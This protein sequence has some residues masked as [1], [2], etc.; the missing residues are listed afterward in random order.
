MKLKLSTSI[1]LI[2][3]SLQFLK[4]QEQ[5]IPIETRDIGLYLTVNPK[6]D[7]FMQYLGQKLS[8]PADILYDYNNNTPNSKNVEG[9]AYPAFGN[10]NTN[11]V[12]LKATHADGNLTT[13]LKYENHR[14]IRVSDNIT[15]TEVNLKD[16]A[17][18]FR[19]SLYYKA[20]SKENVFEVH[21]RIRHQESKAVKLQG[22]ASG[23]L[24]L[25]ADSYWL[26]HFYGAWAAEM[27]MVEECL[28][29]GIK[30]VDSKKGIRTTQSESPSFILSLDQPANEDNGNVIIG[31]LGWSGN[32]K[33]NFQVDNLNNLYAFGGMSDF[34]SDYFLE[35]DT[36]MTL[37]PLIFTYSTSGTGNA[38]R[39]L[40]RWAREYQLRDGNKVR[41]VMLNS[42]EGAYFNFDEKTIKDMI[43]DAALMGVELFVLDDGWFGN[44]YPRN[45]D[46]AGLGDWEVNR[47]KLP[48]GLEALIGY[49]RSKNIRFGIWVEPEMANPKSELAEKHPEWVVSGKNREPIL[50]RSQLVLDLT[51][52][53]VQDF[54][55]RCVADLLSQH[56]DIAYIKWDANRH[57]ENLSSTFLPDDRQSHFWI[58][59]IKGLYKVYEKL[60]AQF[61]DVIF[62]ACSSGGGRADYGALKYHHEFWASDNTDAL[63][64][65]YINWGFNQI[66]PAISLGSHVSVSPNHQTQHESP[67]KFRFDVAMSQRLGLE[68]QP[69]LLSQDEL[70]WTQKAVGT[71]KGIREVVQSGNQY[72]L[73]SPYEQKRASMMYVSDD[74]SKAILF[75]YILGYHYREDYPVIKLKGLDPVKQYR[76]TELLPLQKKNK[77]G[78]SVDKNAFA[79][80]G[81]VFSGDFLMK[82]GIRIL[83][84]YTYESAVFE[85]TEVK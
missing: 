10:G 82:Y 80:N 71:Y 32:Y 66:F 39:N 1:C 74:Q 67:I 38:S 57:I 68:L 73:I 43:D 34:M 33:L 83:I 54:V 4:A 3:L 21:A 76:I 70:V 40:H 14:T 30:T 78:E 44:K 75:A 2:I 11:E 28:T 17:Y 77:K 51:H 13:V 41:P 5:V 56:P 8:K 23:C 79:G 15:L 9:E 63:T 35:P 24:T 7:V 46:K 27:R 65:L 45:S 48:H 16:P 47:K 58:E 12:A 69:K 22:F 20:Y 81:K 29:N 26:T 72:R 52:P 25:K 55:Y 36:D 6:G 31:T 62:Q 60:A 53:A 18:P 19:V 64:R 42:W 49:A 84:R 59:Y 85:I 50:W 37:P 61:P